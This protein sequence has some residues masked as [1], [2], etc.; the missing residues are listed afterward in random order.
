MTPTDVESQSRD[1]E[2]EAELRELHRELET[3]TRFNGTTQLAAFFALLVALAAMLGVA[4]KLDGAQNGSVVAQPGTAPG[5]MAGSGMMANG[6]AN[7]SSPSSVAL[8]IEH[9]QTGCHLL[10]VSGATPGSDQT[11]Q[12]APGGTVTITNSDVMPHVLKA[13]GGPAAKVSGANMSHMGAQSKVSFAKAGT[14]SFN[15]KAGEDYP[16]AAGIQTIG[17]D[18][19]LSL[20]VVVS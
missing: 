9:A 3:R 17:P 5:Q 20:T 18:N 19:K 10:A 15:T 8:T 11:V 13:T 4:F 2:I 1:P 6:T 14:Y 12:L 7:S 16:S